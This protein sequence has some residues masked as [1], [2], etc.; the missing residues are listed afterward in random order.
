MIMNTL[1]RDPERPEASASASRQ[2]MPV[3]ETRLIP[4]G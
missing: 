4:Q 2:V 1:G 3:R